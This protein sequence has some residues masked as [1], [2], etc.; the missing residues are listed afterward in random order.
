MAAA[1]NE[2][3]S[4]W[5]M[6]DPDWAYMGQC[7]AKGLPDGLVKRVDSDGDIIYEGHMKETGAWHGFVVYYC[8]GEIYACWY[9]DGV[10]NGN[11]AKFRGADLT[12]T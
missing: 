7:N 2:Y 9:D 6:I 8:E 3:T 10:R 12:I 4:V 11:F 1:S 5:R